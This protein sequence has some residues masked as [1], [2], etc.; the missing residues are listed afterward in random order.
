[1]VAIPRAPEMMERIRRSYALALA[2]SVTIIASCVVVA[3]F[4]NTSAAFSQDSYTEHSLPPL[5]EEWLADRPQCE[6]LFEGARDHQRFFG[7]KSDSFASE[8]LDGPC[9]SLEMLVYADSQEANAVRV[10]VED[11]EERFTEV[12]VVVRDNSSLYFVPFEVENSDVALGI[13]VLPPFEGELWFMVT[14]QCNIVVRGLFMVETE[15]DNL[16]LGGLQ[17]DPSDVFNYADTVR[18]RIKE[19]YCPRSGTGS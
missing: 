16:P 11:A 8:T 7:D 3:V 6:L 5:P 17:I 10:L 18:E 19:G 15:T 13:P 4:F 1:M 12:R 14:S 2:V 9:A